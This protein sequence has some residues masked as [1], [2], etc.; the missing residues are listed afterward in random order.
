MCNY[1]G[2]FY[3]IFVF[4][5]WYWQKSKYTQTAGRIRL[6]IDFQVQKYMKNKKIP[7]SDFFLKIDQ[8]LTKKDK[9]SKKW[10]F[11]AKSENFTFNG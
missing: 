9:S 1:I 10:G 4:L 3:M 2:K 5:S 7:Q 8:F 6:K 11:Q